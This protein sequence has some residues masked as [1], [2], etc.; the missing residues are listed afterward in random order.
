LEE[1]ALFELGAIALKFER[2]DCREVMHAVWCAQ[3]GLA[4]ERA[5]Y[6]SALT[7][8]DLVVRTDVKVL[9]RCLLGLTVHALQGRESVRL[10]GV[11]R[12]NKAQEFVDICVSDEGPGLPVRVSILKSPGIP[13]LSCASSGAQLRLCRRLAKLIHGR[14]VERLARGQG[15]LFILTLPVA[16]PVRP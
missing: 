12:L 4:A 14:I 11:K 1:L 9:E 5:R 7:V 16:G 8:A 13:A 15:R 3:E 10:A 2:I 6:R